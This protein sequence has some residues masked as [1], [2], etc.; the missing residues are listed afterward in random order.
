MKIGD[1]IELKETVTEKNVASAAGSGKL[2]VYGTPYMIAL[3][4]NAAHSLLEA[5]LEA[6][7]STVGTRVN[8]NHISPSPV[9]MEVR[10]VAEIT[11]ISE[12]RKIIDFKVTCY[13]SAGLIGEG[14]H[15]RAIISVDRFMEKSS[16]KLK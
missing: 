1:K 16:A 2:P 10:A 6:G 7:R 15:Q 4:E 13:D 9:G 12:N 14:T 11:G 3:C 8:I 5:D